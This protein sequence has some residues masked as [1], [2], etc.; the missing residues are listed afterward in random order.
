[1]TT[2]V[3]PQKLDLNRVVKAIKDKGVSAKCPF[4]G[5]ESWSLVDELVT[6][7]PLK[8]HGIVLGNSYPA[9][10]LVCTGCGYMA[11]FSAKVLGLYSED[12]AEG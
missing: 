1:M 2:K 8:N 3:A 4:S 12:E 7:I 11:L 6:A 5:H 9:I 10:M